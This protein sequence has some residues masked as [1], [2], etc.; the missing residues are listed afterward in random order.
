MDGIPGSTQ[1]GGITG[2]PSVESHVFR[3]RRWTFLVIAVSLSL[4]HG[5]SRGRPHFDRRRTLC[6][7]QPP[8]RLP[9]Y[10]FRFELSNTLGA[11]G[12]CVYGIRG[13]FVAPWTCEPLL[14]QRCNLQPC[15]ESSQDSPQITSQLW[16]TFGLNRPS[17]R[18]SKV[19]GTFIFNMGH[20]SRN[21]LVFLFTFL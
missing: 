14:P 16:T 5:S 9:G 19:L 21:R 20:P 13:S 17:N 4:P 1:C 15:R 2:S 18:P 10:C 6:I 3:F 7:A 11:C 12:L 8:W